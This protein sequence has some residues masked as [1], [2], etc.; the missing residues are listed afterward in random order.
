MLRPKLWTTLK[1]YDR[2]Q[3]GR[4]AIAGIIV[5]IVALPLC[6]AFAIASGVSPER[7]LIAGVV[8]GFFVSFLG[9]SRVQIGGPAGAFVV[10]V[11][12]I[13]AEYGLDG[14]IVSTFLA[15]ILL[16]VFGRLG[17]GSVI[18]FIPE[19]VVMGFTSG[20][21]VIIAITQ[22]P[23][24]CGLRM[25]ESSA[26]VIEKIGAITA[27]LG[28]AS[29]YAILI[30]VG[31]VL[32]MKLWPK[33]SRTIPSPMVA[34]VGATVAAYFLKL[35]VE[36][37]GSRFGEIPS[38]LPMPHVPDVTFD[39][40]RRLVQPSITIALLVSIE[41]LL[42]AVVA[43]GMVGGRHRSNMELI[44]QGVANI[45][46]SFFGGLPVTGAIA[47]TATNVR[48]GGRTPIAGIVHAI[49]LMLLM[50]FFGKW[51]AMIPLAALAG[52]LMVVAYNMSEWR[53]FL[54]MLKSPKSDVAVLLVT[55]GLTIIVDLTVAIEVGMV[56]AAF[57]FMQR[58]AAVTDVKVVTGQMREL[59]LAEE[60]DTLDRTGI[61]EGVQVYEINGPFFF[62]AV[63]KFKEAI[64][65]VSK[66]PK[67]RIIQMDKVPAIDSSGLKALDEV[68]HESVHRGTK[69]LI[70][71]IHSQPYVALDRSG[72]LDKFGREN[73][74][75]TFDDT[76]VR[77][78]EILG[79]EP[80]K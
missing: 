57:L 75:K 73:V 46:S 14:L 19:P 29:I 49:M 65:L 18:K 80:T 63:Y 47:R 31:T 27:S 39:Q 77:V 56:L 67:V 4:D 23:D 25:T 43:D 3:F 54:A 45:G 20:I 50:L 30:A 42:S 58:M 61:P 28:T 10:I 1:D 70:S 40:I 41:S 5:G 55:L 15:G 76:L 16:I 64:R 33:V 48:S 69:L 71:G 36:T 7:G 78:H 17:F 13:I 12:G 6:I 66:P 51:A 24:F 44:G 22:I 52:I 21:A 74:F 37:I 72:L 11:Y 79:D 34:L 32:V 68:F 8:G 59:T 35:P 62:G 53:S 9:G 26:N 60:S 38:F 2:A